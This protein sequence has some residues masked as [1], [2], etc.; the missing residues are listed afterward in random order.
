MTT[1]LHRRHLIVKTSPV[2]GYGVFAGEDIEEHD[3]VEECYRLLVGK[4]AELINYSFHADDDKSAI[5]LGYGSIYNHSEEFNATYLYD[6][7]KNAVVFRAL[8]SIL[9]GEEIFIS[10]GNDW[11]SSRDLLPM[12]RPFRYKLLRFFRHTRVL[13]RGLIVI[14]LLI[15]MMHY[16][17]THG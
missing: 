15:L 3:V 4:S 9:K 11:F 12:P 6:E 7:E 13:L 16:L 1:T 5:L 10:Y 14:T 2:H 8:R 17:G